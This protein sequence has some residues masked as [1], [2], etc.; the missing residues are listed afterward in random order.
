MLSGSW[1]DRDQLTILGSAP[2]RVAE[3]RHED[4]FALLEQ[5]PA[6]EAPGELLVGGGWVGW[7]GYRLGSRIER[8]PPAPPAPV[9]R[10]E[11]SLAFYDHLVLHDGERWWFEALVS[12]EREREIDQR[13]TEWRRRLERTPSPA[14]PRAPGAFHVS[15]SG[16][17]SH[18]AAVSDCRRRIAEGEIFQAN[19]CLRLEAE[20]PGEAIELLPQ[21]LQA[22]QP[23]FG[24]FMDGVLSLSPERFLRRQGRTVSSEP[25]KGTRPRVGDPAERDAARRALDESI[26]DHAEHVMIV[27]LMRNDLG[28][29]CEFGTVTAGSPRV[30]AHAGVWHLVST[31]SGELRDGVA[32]GALLRASFPP[33]S[34]T[35]APKVQAMKVISALETTAREAYTGA[36]GI[37]SP[38]AGLDLSVAI[39]TFEFAPGTVWFGAG[40]GIVADSEADAELTE[41]LAKAAGPIAAL[42]AD[43]PRPPARRYPDISRIERALDH[44]SRADPSRGLFATLLV[45]DGEPVHLSEHLAR[46]ERS[47]QALWGVSLPADAAARACAAASATAGRQRL[48]IVAGPAGEIEV[49]TEPAAAPPPAP[50]QLRP[51]VLPGGFGPHKWWDRDLAATLSALAPGTMP[52]FIDA[53]GSVLEAATA[54]VWIAE[55]EE[56]LTPPT[57]GRILPGVTRLHLLAQTPNARE[58]A[59]DIERLRDADQV[60]LSSSIAGYRPAQLKLG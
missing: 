25:I 24:A 6:I 60:L 1:L 46:L 13:L 58:Q 53:D 23:R 43:L 15:A 51:Y 49:T 32:D 39:R 3:P 57:D 38:V 40:G 55:G 45:Q 37:A 36:I 21:A 12:A 42:G 48:R 14:T 5:Q 47:L 28:R 17:G 19:L 16:P 30:E 54:N 59:F 26:K 9:T 11:F 33:G 22:A 8:L 34:V 29:V 18:L 52:L 10:P 27:D 4:P 56:L 35:G 2:A 50:V 20:D 44:G 7:L 41:A 31:V